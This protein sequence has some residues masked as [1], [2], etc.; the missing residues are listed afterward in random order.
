[1]EHVPFILVVRLLAVMIVWTR[2]TA[3]GLEQA[4][5]LIVIDLEEL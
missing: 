5:V 4:H 3:L 1:M 2:A